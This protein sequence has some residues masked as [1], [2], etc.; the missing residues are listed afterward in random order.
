MIYRWVFDSMREDGYDS[1]LRFRLVPTWLG[2]LL[3]CRERYREFVG[4]CTVW[5]WFPSYE[6]TPTL[7]DGW[8]H[9]H[10]KRETAAR[11]RQRRRSGVRKFGEIEE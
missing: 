10:W 11:R 5:Y 6:R 2:R 9:Q 4:N 8:F 1:I 3:G 7:W